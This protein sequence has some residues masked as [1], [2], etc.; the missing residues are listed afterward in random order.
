MIYLNHLM[1]LLVK[2]NRKSIE[3]HSTIDN[4]KTMYPIVAYVNLLCNN[5]L[6]R[7]RYRL[8]RHGLAEYGGLP[9]R[10]PDGKQMC[11]P[12]EGG[13]PGKS[14]SFHDQIAM[15]RNLSFHENSRILV[16]LLTIF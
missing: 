16:F 1:H 15:Y 8:Q 3:L 2:L 12:R 5:E 14:Q 13:R 10:A 4:D 11:C 6:S 9:P 7:F